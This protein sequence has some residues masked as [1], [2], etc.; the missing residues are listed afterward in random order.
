MRTDF[1]KAWR[2]PNQL[3][4]RLRKLIPHW[5]PSPK[6]GRP[7]LDER[8]VADGIFYV[9]RIGCPWKAAPPQ[10]GSG[11]SLHHY[12]QMWTKHGVFQ[13]LW[14]KSLLEYDRR[15]RIQWKWQSLDCTFAKAPLGGEKTGKNPTDRG[16]LGTK[17]SMMTDARGVPLSIVIA[18]ANTPDMRLAEETLDSIPIHR[19]RPKPYRRQHLCMDLGY[20]YASLKGVT[21]RR[22]YQT[23]IPQ[24]RKPGQTEVV[25][26]FH[27]G[28]KARRW[29]NERTHSWFN[30][31]RRVVVRWEKKE[32]NYLAVLHFVAAYCTLRVT[33]VFG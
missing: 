33:G 23:H 9:L 13:S 14:K 29:V 12:F 27:S 20:V 24:K 7:A 22:G 1:P 25:S 11:S 4:K 3:W 30:R 21:S 32:A 6:G 17:R 16:K 8:R 5:R 18:G 28:G 15:R 10:F 19:P 26:R 2:L 31:F